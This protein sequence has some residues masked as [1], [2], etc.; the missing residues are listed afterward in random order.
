MKSKRSLGC[1]P[2]LYPEPAL[3][4]ATYD[5]AGKPNA[6]VAAWGGICCSDPLCLTVSV[7]PG[8][9]TFQPMLDRKAFTVCIASESM[10][11]SADF[12]GMASGREYDKFADAGWT[13]V[14]AEKV[15]A[16]YICESPVILECRLVKTV[17]LGAHTMMIGQI[18]DVKADEDCLDPTG[19]HPD[20]HKVAPLVFDSGSKNYYAV[21]KVV[22]K[23]FA[24]GNGLMKK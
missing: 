16:P 2:L 6:M 1:L 12:A 8:R 4:V 13:A 17:E 19:S 21:G 3:L 5:A 9:W 14:K 24:S 18:M 7:R 20:I 15:D 22:G 23:A 10:L 11:V